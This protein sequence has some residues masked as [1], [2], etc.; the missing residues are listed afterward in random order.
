[1]TDSEQRESGDDLPVRRLLK[2]LPK[3]EASPD[4]EMRLHR[5]IEE[6]KNASSDGNILASVK[7]RFAFPAYA[8]SLLTVVV[9]MLISYYAFFRSSEDPALPGFDRPVLRDVRRQAARPPSVAPPAEP[10][11]AA[12]DNGAPANPPAV[13]SEV[14]QDPQSFEQRTPGPSPRSRSVPQAKAREQAMPA[15]EGLLPPRQETK[16]DPAADAA[17]IEPPD[18]EHPQQQEN[19]REG[20]TRTL[21]PVVP[22]TDAKA[23]LLNSLKQV[24]APQVL[25]FSAPEI[26]DSSA[27]NDTTSSDSLMRKIPSIPGIRKPRVRKPNG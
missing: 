16:Q 15:T 24:A 25:M 12:T 17:P 2:E 5:G 10:P 4:F 21:A 9:V 7:R 19:L 11:A 8:Y 14:T 18:P 23:P 20:E 3:V 27:V 13:R 6:A 22:S 1:M 26:A